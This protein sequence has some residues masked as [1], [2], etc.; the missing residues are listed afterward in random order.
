LLQ[1]GGIVPTKTK[2]LWLSEQPVP[3]NV[4][5]A[6]EGRWDLRLCRRGEPLGGQLEH[7]ALVVAYPNGQADDPHRLAQL[8][9]AVDHSPAVAL[10]LLPVAARTAWGV[11]GRREGKFLCL[12]QDASS[13]EIAAKLDAAEA[14]QPAI[15]NLQR[16]LADARKS[17][18]PNMPGLD[19]IDEE[20][21]LAAR[22]QRD[23]LPRRLPVVGP[24]RFAVL[25]RPLGWVS[26]DIYDV[27]RLDETHLGFYVADAVGHG[28][29]AALLTMFIKH[30]LQTKRILGKTYQIL[31]P[32]ESLAALN[33]AIC[34][35][36]LSSCQF[37]TA[38]YCV[39]DLADL[40]LTYARA[41]H[42][43]GLLIHADGTLASLPAPGSL[44]GV[45]PEETYHSVS[46]PLSPGDRLV[47]YTDGVEDALASGA[48]EPD[49]FRHLLTSIGRLPREQLLLHIT[50]LIDDRSA[51]RN[52][53]D[54][55]TVLVADVEE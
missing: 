42:P 7:A 27:A 6:A 14:L 4:T 32:H 44:L 12:R 41:G 46:V 30:A 22:I 2:L 52:A 45:F 15:R 50:A 9:D 3:S 54:D 10:V 51:R 53:E 23:F 33:A 40:T 5:R 47:L 11:L 16:E 55:I 49:R 35:Q 1:A 39:L 19:E 17:D 21:R 18:H 8:L 38:V 31:P 24:I 26:G 48:G 36:N 37:C 28:M 13:E 20:M 43:E 25:Y 34:E 29:P